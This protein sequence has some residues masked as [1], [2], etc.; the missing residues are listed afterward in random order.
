[1]RSAINAAV[2]ANLAIY[3]VDTRGLQ[4][5]R[6]WAMRRRQPARHR[7]LQRRRAAQQHERQLRLA[8]SDGHAEHDTGGKA[9]FDSNDFAPAFAQGA[10]RHIG[11]LRNRISARIRRATASIA[12]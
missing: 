2:R 3:S 6:R 11:L 4:A 8:G 10:A 5:S 12:S 1:L 9:F 7:R